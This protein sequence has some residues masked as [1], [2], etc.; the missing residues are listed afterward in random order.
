MLDLTTVDDGAVGGAVDFAAVVFEVAFV[1]ALL[2]GWTVVFAVAA[3]VVFGDG[4]IVLSTI[5]G[6]TVASSA[7]PGDLVTAVTVAAGA[8][9]GAP[10]VGA[11]IVPMVKSRDDCPDCVVPP[12]P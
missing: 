5:V 11:G 3:S 10:P 8:R 4:S 1:S 9:V 6:S 7:G 12:L 2:V